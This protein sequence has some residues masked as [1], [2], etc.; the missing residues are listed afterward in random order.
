MG[1]ILVISII[2]VFGAFFGILHVVNQRRLKHLNAIAP[3]DLVSYKGINLVRDA[4]HPTNMIGDEKG[5]KIHYMGLDQHQRIV[6]PESK[7]GNQRRYY[8][9]AT[10]F[11]GQMSAQNEPM[12]NVKAAINIKNTGT[13]DEQHTNVYLTLLR[14]DFQNAYKIELK[15]QNPDIAQINHYYCLK[16]AQLKKLRPLVEQSLRHATTK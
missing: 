5:H 9:M 8:L 16:A 3:D 14:C 15:A 2:I 4:Q 12:T 11:N 10:S 6:F 13:L 1:I 7:F